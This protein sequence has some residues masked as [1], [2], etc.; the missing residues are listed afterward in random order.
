MEI[1][2]LGSGS[3]F[4]RY[5]TSKENTYSKVNNNEN[6]S[7]IGKTLR[8]SLLSADESEETT[9]YD[10]LDTNKDGI[11]DASEEE[12]GKNEKFGSFYSTQDF[13]SLISMGA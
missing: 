8:T 2:S 1:T 4:N 11:I 9:E 7:N 6:E 12:A 3:F 13:L 5:I 10:P